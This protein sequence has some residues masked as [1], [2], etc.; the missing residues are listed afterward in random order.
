MLVRNINHLVPLL[1][2]QLDISGP[3]ER[4]SRLEAS[5]CDNLPSDRSMLQ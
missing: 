2:L 1:L 3:A 5:L 4:H